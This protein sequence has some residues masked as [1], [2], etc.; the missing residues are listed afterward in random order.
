MASRSFDKIG[1]Q[2][3]RS[4][5]IKNLVVAHDINCRNDTKHSLDCFI[6]LSSNSTSPR[7]FTNTSHGHDAFAPVHTSSASGLWY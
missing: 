4:M 6:P 7:H 5:Y 1:G 2:I 3:G